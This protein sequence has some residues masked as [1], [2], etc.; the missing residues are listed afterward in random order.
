MENVRCRY[1]KSST[2]HGVSDDIECAQW[3]ICMNYDI[4]C[5]MKCPK[6]KDK[7]SQHLLTNW[8]QIAE[9]AVTAM[10][11]QTKNTV[12]LNHVIF[13]LKLHYFYIEL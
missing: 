3:L 9:S 1:I 5:N 4:F 2:L 12:Y 7:A 8:K 13:I 6:A 10:K 11:K